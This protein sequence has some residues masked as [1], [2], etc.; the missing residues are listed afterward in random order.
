MTKAK[1]N[2]APLQM[3]EDNGGNLLVITDDDNYDD[4]DRLLNV[5]F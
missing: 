5:L 4:K 2:K 1:G 3:T